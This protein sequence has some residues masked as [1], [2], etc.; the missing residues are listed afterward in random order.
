MKLDKE[1]V[2]SILAVLILGLSMIPILYLARYVHATG[3]DY[4]MGRSRMR[5]GWILIPY[6]RC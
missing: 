1:K 6:G 4:D 3:D 2:I 5:P